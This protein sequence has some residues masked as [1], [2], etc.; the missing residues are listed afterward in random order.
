MW[1][2]DEWRPWISAAWILG[3]GPH[4]DTAAQ[5]SIHPEPSKLGVAWTQD[6]AEQEPRN[7]IGFEIPIP[8]GDHNRFIRL[9]RAI[10]S[11]LRVTFEAS[12]ESRIVV[13]S[14]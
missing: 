9:P 13:R 3:F 14:R 6:E 11:V 5:S 4:P 8:P 7:P 2:M 1:P 12:S 10:A